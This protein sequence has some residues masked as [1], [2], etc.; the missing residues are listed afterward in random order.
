VALETLFP[1]PRFVTHETAPVAVCPSNNI[2]FLCTICTFEKTPQSLPHILD[3]P[4]Y[5]AL[6]TGNKKLALGNPAVQYIQREVGWF[7]GMKRN[8][9]KALNE[10]HQMLPAGSRIILFTSKELRIPNSWTII[11]ARP[12]LQM[13]CTKKQNTVKGT[14]KIVPLKNKHIPAMLR[15]THMTNPGPFFKRTIAFGNYEGIFNGRQLVAITGRRLQ[16][17]NYAEVSA[18]CTHP[19][20]TGKGYAAQLVQSQV[21]KIF[22]AA[23]IPFLHVYPD[24]PAVHLYKKMGFTIRNDCL[25]FGK[26]YLIALPEKKPA[27]KHF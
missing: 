4:I 20:H 21:D 13:V 22:A 6:I 17:G 23:K 19:N 18:V 11:A 14:K 7:A 27:A 2:P 8:S 24:N 16:A 10:L 15:L 9:Q 1:L 12:L 5:N 26:R 25:F 3:N